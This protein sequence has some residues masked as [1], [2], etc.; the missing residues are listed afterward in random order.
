MPGQPNIDIFADG[1][2]G[3]SRPMALGKLLFQIS[4]DAERQ[5]AAG[6]TPAHFLRGNTQL[7][8]TTSILQ[9]PNPI[10]PTCP[11]PSSPATFPASER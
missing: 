3:A 9:C 11:M 1:H 2:H 6:Q 8:T 10:C 7:E 4:A 5:Q